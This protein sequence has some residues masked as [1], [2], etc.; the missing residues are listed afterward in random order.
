MYPSP[1]NPTSTTTPSAPTWTTRAVKVE[2][3]S[4]C[5]RS[6]SAN[7]CSMVISSIT[8]ASLVT[9]VSFRGFSDFSIEDL[10]YDEMVHREGFEPS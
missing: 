3:T 10:F 7:N 4:D 9:G 2:P 6:T 5:S 8:A 1:F